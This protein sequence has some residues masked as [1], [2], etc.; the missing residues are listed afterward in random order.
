MTVGAAILAPEMVEVDFCDWMGFGG[1][2]SEKDLAV[3]SA[4][5]CLNK[6]SDA[7]LHEF[8][9]DIGAVVL[10]DHERRSELV[11]QGL[12]ERVAE[13]VGVGVLLGDER[14]GRWLLGRDETRQKKN[15]DGD[16]S[17]GRKD[18]H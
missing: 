7:A 8:A 12:F 1:T 4:V 15:A 3:D 16:N 18:M 10:A 9:G 5:F 14:R 2:G 13:A 11:E 6:R 17:R